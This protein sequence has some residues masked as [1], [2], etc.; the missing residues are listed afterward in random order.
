MVAVAV[1]HVLGDTVDQVT[2]ILGNMLDRDTCLRTQDRA[3]MTH[4]VQRML[5]MG[6]CE[7]QCGDAGRVTEGQCGHSWVETVVH[8]DFPPVLALCTAEGVEL[9]GPVWRGSLSWSSVE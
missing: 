5:W 9:G 4:A 1:T 2:D 6:H 7:V 8:G 3:T